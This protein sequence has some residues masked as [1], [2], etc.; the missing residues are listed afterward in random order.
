MHPPDAPGTEPCDW[1]WETAAD[2][3]EVHALLTACDAHQATASGTPAPRRRPETTRWLVESG[4][5]HLLRHTTGPAGMFTLTARP[6]SG[7]DESVFP[8]AEHPLYLSRLAVAPAWLAG[9]ALVGLRCVRQAVETAAGLG[10]DTLRAQVNPD[11]RDTCSLLDLLGFTPCGPASADET[12]RR[13]AHL[14]RPLTAPAADR[15]GD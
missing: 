9:G 1:S 8:P 7:T 15:R 2:P 10:G 5:V 4:S 6:P 13:H 12:G 3:D 11:L 14:H